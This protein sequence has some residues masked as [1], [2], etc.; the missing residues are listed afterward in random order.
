MPNGFGP[1][2]PASNA[3]AA[4]QWLMLVVHHVYERQR[5]DEAGLPKLL[6][7]YTER[8]E[9]V[10]EWKGRHN[11]W[12]GEEDKNIAIRAARWAVWKTQGRFIAAV[13]VASGALSLAGGYLLSLINITF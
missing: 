13:V 8:I 12:H 5:D 11:E 3:E 2:P 4:L 1:M 7:E 9:A 10:E 6:A